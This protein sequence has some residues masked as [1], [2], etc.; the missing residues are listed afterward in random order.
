MCVCACLRDCVLSLPKHA[1]VFITKHHQGELLWAGV[2]AVSFDTLTFTDE[3][4][5]LT[6]FSDVIIIKAIIHLTLNFPIETVASVNIGLLTT[7]S[8]LNTNIKDV[9]HVTTQT[10]LIRIPSLLIYDSGLLK[11]LFDYDKHATL[12]M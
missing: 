12:D 3:T 1:E 7:N 8:R 5:S 4:S 9:H 2:Q 10:K 6:C 11:E